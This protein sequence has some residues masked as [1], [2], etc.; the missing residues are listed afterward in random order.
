MKSGVEWKHEA[1]NHKT[2]TWLFWNLKG[3]VGD[4]ILSL[5]HIF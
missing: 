5:G 4:H 3:E 2:L 1:W